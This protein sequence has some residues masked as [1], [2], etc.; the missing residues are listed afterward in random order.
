ML[1]CA[2]RYAYFLQLDAAREH[3]ERG[4]QSVVKWKFAM[5][6]RFVEIPFVDELY[7]G[8]WVQDETHAFPHGFGL[9]SRLTFIKWTIPVVLTYTTSQIE[10]SFFTRVGKFDRIQV[11]R[12]VHFDDQQRLSSVINIT[13]YR[14]CIR[15]YKYENRQLITIVSREITHSSLGVDSRK[16]ITINSDTQRN[17]AFSY[18]VDGSVAT[19]PELW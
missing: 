19:G 6:P 1:E 8:A 4:L 3:L 14:S 7:N 2:D 12:H 18:S 11:V 10:E 5:R 16:S 13:D 9:D 17:Y 15:E